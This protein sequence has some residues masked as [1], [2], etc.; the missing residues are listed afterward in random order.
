MALQN[1]EY[2]LL[3]IP[4]AFI[5][6]RVWSCTLEILFVYVGVNQHNT[7]AWFTPLMILS[8]CYQ[9]YGNPNSPIDGSSLVYG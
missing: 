3:V 8:V 2:K 1:V 4:V 9:L 7:P 6:F 5:I